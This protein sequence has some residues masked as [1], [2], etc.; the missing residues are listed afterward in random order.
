MKRLAIVAGILAALACTP[1][2][3]A[4]A[5][6]PGG[7]NI[8]YY[9]DGFDALATAQAFSPAIVETP[10]SDVTSTCSREAASGDVQFARVT[11]NCSNLSAL[12]HTIGATGV[13]N[14]SINYPSG[15][16]VETRVFRGTDRVYRRDH[17]APV[18]VARGEELGM[19]HLGSTVVL[20]IKGIRRL[21]VEGVESLRVG[22]VIGRIAGEEP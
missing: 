8:T 6:T 21:A 12:T 4:S 17:D 10:G 19:F 22:Q 20:V 9:F 3:S 5:G 14:I 11:V 18:P 2:P 15:Q 16:P 7:M 13:G 1:A